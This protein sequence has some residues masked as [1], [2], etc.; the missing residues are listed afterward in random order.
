MGELQSALWKLF[1]LLIRHVNVPYVQN[2]IPLH[3]QL[4]TYFDQNLHHQ[5]LLF[6]SSNDSVRFSH[7]FHYEHNILNGLIPQK[8]H[9]PRK[10]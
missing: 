8:S 9:H 5:M 6:L 4:A 1:S 3:E 10:T 2:K 7:N